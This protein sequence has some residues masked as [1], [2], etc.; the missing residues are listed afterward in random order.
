MGMCR[1]CGFGSGWTCRGVQL[2]PFWVWLWGSWRAGT[3]HSLLPPMPGL[4]LPEEQVCMPLHLLNW[5]EHS[6]KLDLQGQPSVKI[7]SDTKSQSVPPPIPGRFKE[8]HAKV[9]M[10]TVYPRTPQGRGDKCSGGFKFDHLW[11]LPGGPVTKTLGSQC[12]EP[13]FEPTHH[14]SEF[15]CQN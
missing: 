12:R 7:N 5:M 13:R 2:G 14:N 3:A 6:D 11:D 4:G 8:Q 15:Q 9:M 1:D 10:N